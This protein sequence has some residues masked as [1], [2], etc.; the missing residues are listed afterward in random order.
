MSDA[1][2]INEG[3]AVI[4]ES[5]K[6]NV[7]FLLPSPIWQIDAANFKDRFELLSE[8]C[9][10][11]IYAW[12]NAEEATIGSFVYRGLVPNAFGLQGKLRLAWRMLQQAFALHKRKKID[13]VVCWD[14]VF[15]GVLGCIL[16]AVLRVRLVIELNNSD[17][18]YGARISSKNA[19][20]GWLKY[21][22]YKV[23]I[24]T[25][26]GYADRIKVLS[27]TLKR[28]VPR[29]F[30]PKVVA[31]HCFTATHVFHNETA[32]YQKRI[33]FVGY[34]FQRK[35]VDVLIQA[36]NKIKNRYPDFTLLLIGHQLHDEVSRFKD[37]DTR[38]IEIKKALS[39][40]ETVEEML[41]CYCF[42]LAS[43]E[44]GLPRVL[45]EAMACGKALVS[46]RVGGI[47]DL[48]V[49]GVNGYL[50]E[51]ED[52]SGFAEKLELLL[53]NPE[54]NQVMGEQSRRIAY[55]QFSSDVYA[56]R[57]REMTQ[58]LLAQ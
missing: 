24:P 48:I 3:S 12:A 40:S 56:N 41:S 6:A 7:L 45:I 19:I 29:R 2:T 16:K 18:P 43:R 54:V 58:T 13:V 11:E 25:T 1:R 35:G 47:A 23:I 51:S 57:F 22:I 46:T 4:Q 8:W 33:L 31:F 55:E 28:Y 36:F 38:Q 37:L 21:G 52:V 32:V 26:C 14:P 27:E 5:K 39:F 44:E 10:G 30:L 50:V 53:A 42:V 15:T 9:E 17:I 20:V 49:D 34:P